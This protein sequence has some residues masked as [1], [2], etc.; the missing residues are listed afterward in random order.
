MKKAKPKK[1]DTHILLAENA[2]VYDPTEESV[3]R[4]VKKKLK[5]INNKVGV[6]EAI[7]P[8]YGTCY[9]TSKPDTGH[10]KT[11]SAALKAYWRK[12]R[13]NNRTEKAE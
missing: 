13:M 5:V 3:E 1:P 11:A 2:A 8:E 12:L 4:M 6:L 7:C 10:H 9:S